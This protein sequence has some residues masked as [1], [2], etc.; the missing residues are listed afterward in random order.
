MDG[1]S[2]LMDTREKVNKKGHI[3]DYLNQRGIPVIRQKLDVGDWTRSDDQTVCI[4]TK[5]CGLLEVYSNVITQHDRFRRELMRAKDNGVQLVVLI[6]ENGINCLDE[7]PDWENPRAKTYELRM[8][9]IIKSRT[10]IPV[11]PPVSSKRMHGIMRT[12]AERYGVIWDF[13]QRERTGARICEILGL[14][15]TSPYNPSPP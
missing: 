5:T 7:V 15:Q 6:E 12:M 4:D 2:I 8:A 9:G 13:C 1:V 11:A 10:P 14:W 3:L